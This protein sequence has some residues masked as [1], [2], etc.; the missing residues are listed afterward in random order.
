MHSP[1]LCV[2]SD[3]QIGVQ[4]RLRVFRTEHA[5]KVRRAKIFEKR[6]LRTENSYLYS[7]LKLANI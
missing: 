5:L 6:M 1:T 2:N 3:L 4:R 7:N